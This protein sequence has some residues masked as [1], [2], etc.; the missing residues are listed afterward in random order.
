MAYKQNPG[1]PRQARTGG[2]LPGNLTSLGPM[3]DAKSGDDTLANY[4]T[5]KSKVVV[6]PA[7]K[8]EKKTTTSYK[9]PTITKAGTDAYNA[10]TPAER[11]AQDKKYIKNNTTKKTVETK[12]VPATR[13]TVKVKSNTVIGKETNNDIK[14]S[15]D[16]KTRN[17]REKLMAEKRLSE[18]TSRRDSTTA[19]NKYLDKMA[20]KRMPNSVDKRDATKLGNNAG[21]KTL[22]AGKRHTNKEIQEN[23]SSM[24][25]TGKDYYGRVGNLGYREQ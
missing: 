19:A 2:N 3:Q 15:G 17:R 13:K 18:T 1:G 20:L 16:Q 5:N 11:K 14:R 21:R 7:I 8:G 24:R 10:L 12:P 25:N 22:K 9:K 6:T 23:Y 4:N